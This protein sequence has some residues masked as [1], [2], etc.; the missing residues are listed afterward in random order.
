MEKKRKCRPMLLCFLLFLLFSSSIISLFF[1]YSF[2]SH[3]KASN[4]HAAAAAAKVRESELSLYS[5]FLLCGSFPFFFLRRN[6]FVALA[7]KKAA[8]FGTTQKSIQPSVES[9]DAVDGYGISAAI[10][11]S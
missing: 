8:V 5:L 1:F 9:G 10:V 11:Y 2:A 4:F 3:Q 7:E 6:S